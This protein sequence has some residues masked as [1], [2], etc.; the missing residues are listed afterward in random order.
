MFII[1]SIFLAKELRDLLVAAELGNV[2]RMRS[3]VSATQQ[4][5]MTH[6]WLTQ[7]DKKN[8]TPLHLAS[9]WGY[10]DVVSFIVDEIIDALEDDEKKKYYL[11]L[12]DYKGRTP[13]FHAVAEDRN[14]VAQVLV[15]KGANVEEATN[16]KHVEPGSTPLMA[17]A[18][19]NN[20]EGFLYLLNSGADLLATRNDGA[21]ATYIA[22]RY[23]HLSILEDLEECGKV[24]KITK[25]ATFRGRSALMTAALHGHLNVCKFL[26]QHGSV[27]NH[28][29]DDKFT[30]LMFAASNGY[31]ELV[32]W[33]LC[34]G[35]KTNLRASN[36][37]TALKLADANGHD[38]IIKCLKMYQ[39]N[40]QK[41]S[42]VSV[43][44]I[45]NAKNVPKNSIKG[46]ED[47]I[48]NLPKKVPIKKV[49][50]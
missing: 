17:C 10:K 29:D 11:N 19:K 49:S 21:D 45:V 5:D 48:S 39:G 33:L 13:L 22:A 20:R 2:E 50:R 24:N 14:S 41:S 8:R 36:G 42:N 35:A 12:K 40:D 7:A 38:E 6:D 32:K 43:S 26:F 9:I 30:A 1:N 27:L 23:G 37:D 3:L 46:K 15:E 25:R 34:N 16:E 4:Y 44:T 28:Q 18:E 47:K 31:T